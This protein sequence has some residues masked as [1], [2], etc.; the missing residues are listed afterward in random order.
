MAAVRRDVDRIWELNTRLEQLFRQWHALTDSKE[1]RRAYVPTLAFPALGGRHLDLQNTYDDES[2]KAKIAENAD[3]MEAIAV[4][5]FEKAPGSL[6]D[7][8]LDEDAAFNPY[9]IGLDPD[10]WSED[11]LYSDSGLTLS[12]ARQRTQGLENLWVDAIAQPA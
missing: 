8:A 7:S 11:G 9:A 1:W 4:A 6:G 10:R 2:L 12:A 5:V 3:L